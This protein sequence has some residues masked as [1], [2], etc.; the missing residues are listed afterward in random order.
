M[1]FNGDGSFFGFLPGFALG[2]IVQ[3]LEAVVDVFETWI[4]Y[5]KHTRTCG[6][7][8]GG[9]E[10]GWGK[11]R[12]HGRLTSDWRMLLSALSDKISARR[13]GLLDDYLFYLLNDL[14]HPHL[15]FFLVLLVK[16]VLIGPLDTLI[17]VLLSPKRPPCIPL[18]HQPLPLCNK[19]SADTAFLRCIFLIKLTAIFSEILP[20]LSLSILSK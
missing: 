12:R 19:L 9:R 5:A 1:S 17:G 10:Y 16:H 13:A 20:D 6:P 15:D 7:E 4:M 18:I 2:A 14:V 3:S 11:G 8:G